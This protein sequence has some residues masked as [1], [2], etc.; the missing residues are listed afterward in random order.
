MFGHIVRRSQSL[1]PSSCV[2]GVLRQFTMLNFVHNNN[3]NNNDNKNIH[4]SAC[5]QAGKDPPKTTTG[6]NKPKKTVTKYRKTPSNDSMKK[7]RKSFNTNLKDKISGELVD[8]RSEEF[9]FLDHFE[10]PTRKPVDAG[11]P[12]KPVDRTFLTKNVLLIG[13]NG[14]SMGAMPL[15]EAMREAKEQK[16]DL[17]KV[18][19]NRKTG[20]MIYK[21]LN[22]REMKQMKKVPT[23]KDDVVSKQIKMKAGIGKEDLVLKVA[24]IQ[25][26][27]D[28][29]YEV[30][31]SIERARKKELKPSPTSSFTPKMTPAMEEA[32][33][34]RKAVVLESF[35]Q[36]V[37][38]MLKGDFTR[39]MGKANYNNINITLKMKPAGSGG[40]RKKK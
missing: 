5:L 14:K 11:A 29:S 38:K 1:Y 20:Q 18:T 27:L 39:H 21:L 19:E 36:D 2:S 26:F 16:V 10:A 13:L 34:K 33:K 30:V 8:R 12:K 37:I 17:D 25:E 31:L 23:T 3:N 24:K 28:L 4:T 15:S 22:K 35:A 7:T 9:N 32:E 40:E 6:T